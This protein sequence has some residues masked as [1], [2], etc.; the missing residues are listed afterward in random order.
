[1]NN[2]VVGPDFVRDRLKGREL[3]H[4][5]IEG[6]ADDVKALPPPA[7]EAYWEHLAEVA[8]GSLPP[9]TAPVPLTAVQEMTEPELRAFE[10]EI[11]KFEK[12]RGYTVGQTM[13]T[14]D[15]RSYLQWLSTLRFIDRLRL[16]LKHPTIQRELEDPPDEE[17][18]G[19]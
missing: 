13:A 14:A 9:P 19:P 1:M 16:Y 3:A 15:G 2:T 10:N 17:E 7:Q 11:V 18:D 4:K 5:L 12:Y 6:M 8:K